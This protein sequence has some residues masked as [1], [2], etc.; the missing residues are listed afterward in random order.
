MAKIKQSLQNDSDEEFDDED[1]DDFDDG[2][3][4]DDD[5]ELTEEEINTDWDIVSDEE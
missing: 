5:P 1:D 2:S 4:D 3:G